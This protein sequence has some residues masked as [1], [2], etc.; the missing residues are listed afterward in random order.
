M[1]M[2][3]SSLPDTQEVDTYLS[4]FY[5]FVDID[6]LSSNIISPRVMIKL[7]YTSLIPIRCVNCYVRYLKAFVDLFESIHI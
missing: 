3:L 6:E 1:T 4:V 5:D 2:N 7:I